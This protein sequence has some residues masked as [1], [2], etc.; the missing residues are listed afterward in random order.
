M[1]DYKVVECESLRK[2]EREV[3]SLI[4]EGYELVGGVSSQTF[5]DV[6]DDHT[7]RAFYAQA[8]VKREVGR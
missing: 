1:A 3:S 6:N 2:L 4:D 8:L 7:V 5:V